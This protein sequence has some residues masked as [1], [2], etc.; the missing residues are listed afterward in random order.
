MSVLRQPSRVEAWEAFTR[1]PV[2]ALDEFEFGGQDQM[3]SLTPEQ[4]EATVVTTLDH[5]AG[6]RVSSGGRVLYSFD[7][8]SGSAELALLDL[9]TGVSQ[10]LTR[11]EVRDSL[12]R[13][14]A[15]GRA[16]TFVSSMRVGLSPTPFSVPRVLAL[17]PRTTK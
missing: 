4:L 1:A 2:D 6:L 9:D 10:Q 12:P 17:P 11:N 8:G 15:D 13:L 5:L 7:S 16:V 14:T 3:V